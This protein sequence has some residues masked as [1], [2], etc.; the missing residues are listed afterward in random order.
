MQFLAVL[1][2][3]HPVHELHLGLFVREDAG[4]VCLNHFAQGLRIY[5]ADGPTCDLPN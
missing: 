1:G 5:R 2:P 3:R 4:R